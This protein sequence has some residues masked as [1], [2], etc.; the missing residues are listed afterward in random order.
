M[1]HAE[2]TCARNLYLKLETTRDQNCAVLLLGC[3]WNFG[4]KSSCYKTLVRK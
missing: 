3:V 4:F 2:E 1:T